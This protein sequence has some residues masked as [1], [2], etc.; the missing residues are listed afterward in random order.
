MGALLVLIIIISIA[1]AG[2]VTAVYASFAFVAAMT[3]MVASTLR[4]NGGWKRWEVLVL[5]VAQVSSLAL[6]GVSGYHAVSVD[7]D[8]TVHEVLGGADDRLRQAGLVLFCGGLLA[9]V[10]FSA[11][12]TL[13]R[14]L[15]REWAE[16]VSRHALAAM[17]VIVASMGVGGAF[18]IVWKLPSLF[19]SLDRFRG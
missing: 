12:Q 10:I 11:S 5:I 17:I 7:Y 2:S 4:P 8:R 13:L 14:W 6:A 15:K 16:V 1:L 9:G 19:D 18:A 3:A